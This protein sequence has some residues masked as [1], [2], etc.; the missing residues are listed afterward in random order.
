MRQLAYSGMDAPAVGGFCGGHRDAW[1]TA[2]EQILLAFLYSCS[3]SFFLSTNPLSLPCTPGKAGDTT[4]CHNCIAGQYQPATTQTI[5]RLER[6]S[7]SKKKSTQKR[8][9]DATATSTATSSTTKTSKL[10]A[11]VDAEDEKN[12]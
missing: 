12:C 9:K 11:I 2:R 3:Q 1:S 4:G 10:D 5:C 7:K 6:K 8:H